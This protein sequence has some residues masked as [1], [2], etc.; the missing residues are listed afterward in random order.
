MKVK[1]LYV[2]VF[3]CPEVSSSF[4]NDPYNII[5]HFLKVT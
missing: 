2:I 1:A 5:L 4:N 3:I